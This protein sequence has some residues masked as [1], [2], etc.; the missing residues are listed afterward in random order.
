MRYREAPLDSC[1]FR[2]YAAPR[3]ES[4]QGSRVFVVY[5]VPGSRVFRVYAVP[6]IL[7]RVFVGFAVPQSLA[8]CRGCMRYRRA[9]SDIRLFRVCA[10]PRA[11]CPYY[12]EKFKLSWKAKIRK[13]GFHWE[14]PTQ[15]TK[16]D[17]FHQ[18]AKAI[19][20]IQTRVSSIPS[21]LHD[22]STWTTKTLLLQIFSKRGCVSHRPSSPLDTLQTYTRL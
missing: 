3:I 8:V 21:K 5:A 16:I 20:Q 7:G 15:P 9:L 6:R 18:A 13:W 22:A 10:V 11:L 12:F 19:S 4:Q 2:V 1:V 17:E 14:P